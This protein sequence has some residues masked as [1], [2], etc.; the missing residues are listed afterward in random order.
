M[1][2]DVVSKAS[3]HGSVLLLELWNGVLRLPGCV[4]S[5][6]TLAGSTVELVGVFLQP[7]GTGR[8]MAKHLLQ[9]FIMCYAAIG[10]WG[11]VDV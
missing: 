4:V 7:L 6:E 3:F 11:G 8:I 10:A 5:K 9:S 2:A 1:R